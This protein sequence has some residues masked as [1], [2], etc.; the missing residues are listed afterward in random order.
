MTE[1]AAA[2]EA[3]I[4]AALKKAAK[5]AVSSHGR[6]AQQKNKITAKE[7]KPDPFGRRIVPEIDSD[8]LKKLEEKS[9]KKR[10]PRDPNAGECQ[11]L[12]WIRVVSCF[13]GN[14]SMF[15]I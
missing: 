12:P 10:K 11:S 1:Q 7:T 5:P 9:K 15:C 6:V 3:A 2:E 14:N 8:D 13:F 4:E